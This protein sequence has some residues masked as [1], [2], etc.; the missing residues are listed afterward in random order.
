MDSKSLNFS[1][2]R[3]KPAAARTYRVHGEE[4]SIYTLTPRGKRFGRLH[5]Q[6]ILRQQ[7]FRVVGRG[8][9]VTKQLIIN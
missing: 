4:K 9:A 7:R 8:F 1:S 3:S 5:E 6:A 2:R